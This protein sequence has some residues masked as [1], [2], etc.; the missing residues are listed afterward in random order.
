MLTSMLLK[1]FVSSVLPS[2]SR[3]GKSQRGNCRWR[4]KLTLALN[5]GRFYS[6]NP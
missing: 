1:P 2:P 6:C 3:P 5:K 4:I